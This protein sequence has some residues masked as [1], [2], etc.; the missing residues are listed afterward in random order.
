[1]VDKPISKNESDKASDGGLTGQRLQKAREAMNLT[2]ADIANALHITATY[3]NLI[4][5]NQFQKLPGAIFVRGYIKLYAR[6][7]NLPV[8]EV[9][10]C[11]FEQTGD[12]VHEFKIRPAANEYG[13]SMRRHAM[14]W[15]VG[16]VLLVLI[17]PTLV[18]WLTHRD[19]LDVVE[20]TTQQ[21]T[22]V[23]ENLS[24]NNTSVATSEPASIPP[25][26]AADA[27]MMP[28]QANSDAAQPALETKHQE[29]TSSAT[30]TTANAEEVKSTA[31]L[32]AD[33]KG[34]IIELTE[35]SWIQIKN[36]EGNTVHDAEYQAGDKIVVVDRPPLYV[37]IKNGKAATVS[38]N[39]APVTLS[40]I[41]SKGAARLVV[42]K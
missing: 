4:E 38:F 41:D 31:D 25:N 22:A 5:S 6:L 19:A 2:V 12:P 39:G 16:I 30:E 9:M 26:A 33:Q 14:T 18:W 42:G 35:K 40:N 17:I 7:V 8:D 27:T 23:V 11:Y 10:Q 37:W 24:A 36:I 21:N 1:M 34:L 3:V 28:E 15:A 32:Q 20:T 13:A 29:P